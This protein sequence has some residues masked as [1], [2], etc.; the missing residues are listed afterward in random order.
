M[1]LLIDTHIWLWSLL[2][3]KRLP[4][5]FEQAL[6]DSDN[7]VFVS[8][9]VAWEIFV[10]KGMGRL[11]APDRL[12]EYIAASGFKD[13]PIVF[14]HAEQTLDLP[15]HHRDPFDRML[16]AQAQVEDMVL[17]TVDPQIAKYDVRLLSV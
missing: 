2:G 9:A 7:E 13:L 14:E 8:V 17:V 12:Y 6:L 15:L 4:S 11:E 3:S 5:A 16:I 1:R 10:K